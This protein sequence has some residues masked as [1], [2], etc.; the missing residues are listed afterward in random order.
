MYERIFRSLSCPR[1][2]PSLESEDLGHGQRSSKVL[3]DPK[4]FFFNINGGID[5]PPN[6]IQ[7][8]PSI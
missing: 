8:H 6:F 1:D 2:G 5:S 7:K 4:S 3:F